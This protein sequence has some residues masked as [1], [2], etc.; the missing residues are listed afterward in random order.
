MP[1]QVLDNPKPMPGSQDPD[2]ESNAAGGSAPIPQ[3]SINRSTVAELEGRRMLHIQTVALV[4]LASAAVL[5][6]VY[7]AKLLLVVILVSILLAFVLA[8][9]ADLLVRF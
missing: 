4:I 3:V 2:V 9:V 5:T 6:L 1:E 8:P 7:V